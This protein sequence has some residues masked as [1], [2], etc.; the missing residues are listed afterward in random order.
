MTQIQQ[1]DL[2]PRQ[3]ELL[4]QI[5]QF[6]ANNYYLPTIG[7]LAAELQISRS[8]AFEHINLLRKKGFLD[9][10]E[11]KKRSLRLTAKS[12]EIL[13]QFEAVNEPCQ[14]A[15][16]NGIKLMGRVAAGAPIEAIENAELMS[17]D[18]CFGSESFALEVK[19]D[20]MIEEGI[21]DGDY[22]MCRKSSTANNGQLVV[23]IVDDENATLKRFYKEPGRVRL[24][25]ANRNYSP[26][27]TNNCRIEA[28]VS[29]VIRK[30]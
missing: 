22:V 18:Q 16:I 4:Q 15:E 23:A 27:Y 13:E 26:I 25:P 5:H 17:L 20:S 8:T 14:K 11:G 2:T 10:S 29:G 21:F 3:L 28:V 7:E 12:L 24:E 30:L 9:Q 1:C 19:G 6:Q